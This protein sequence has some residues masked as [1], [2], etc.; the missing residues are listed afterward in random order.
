MQTTDCTSKTSAVRDSTNVLPR[1][2]VTL[3]F[4]TIAP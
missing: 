3:E 2:W 1:Y 4:A